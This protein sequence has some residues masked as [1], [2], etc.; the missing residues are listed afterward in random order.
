MDK[1]VYQKFNQSIYREQLSNGLKVQLLPMEGYHKTYAILTTDFGSIDNHFIPYHQEEAI[2]IPDGVAHFL[3][4]KMFEKKDHDAFDLFGKLGADSNAFTSFTQTSYL[5]STTSNLHEN[6]DVLLDFVQ[7]PYFTDQTVKKEQG[8][9]G[10][11][12]QMYEDDPSWRLYLGILG[13]LYPN[14]PMRIDIAGT[15]ESIGRITPKILMDTYK[16][17]YQP[18]NMNLFLVG[19]L[20]PEETITWIKQNQEQKN[21][22][23]TETPRRLFK[24]NDPT[25][26]DV[27]PFRSLTMDIVRPKVMVGLRGT[28]QF[29]DG[30][31]R[32]H[33][34]LAI[35]LLLDV[36]FDDTSDNYLRLYNNETLDDTFGY[37]FEM[38]RGFHFAYFSSDTDQME[39]FADEIIDILESADQQIEA[40]RTRFEGIKNAELGRLIGL[41]D[42]PEAIANRYAGDLFAGASLM[43]EIQILET[44]TIDDLYQVAKDFITPQGIS[45]YQVVPQHQ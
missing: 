44:I 40:A 29:D 14:D 42:S 19:R 25:A 28:K 26:H 15:I 6:L 39:R 30:K 11:E 23:P 34:K 31:Q 36:L 21:F 38:Q 22:A 9:I 32:L 20:D 43:D 4:H 1:Q 41:L 17:F 12:I 27:I 5:F 2:T 7:D 13:N 3:E 37:N 24:L 18:A 45:V 35:D 33:Y 16:T 8:I 10:Q